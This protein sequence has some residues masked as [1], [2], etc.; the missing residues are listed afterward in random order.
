MHM[1]SA[2]DAPLLT[3]LAISMFDERLPEASRTQEEG[4][5][6]A[7]HMVYCLLNDSGIK[8]NGYRDGPHKSTH[9]LE[10]EFRTTVET[11]E[12]SCLFMKKRH[13]DEIT[14]LVRT[15]DISDARL[16]QNFQK[17]VNTLMVDGIRWGRIVALFYFTSVLAERLYKEGHQSKI[18]SLIGWLSLFSNETVVP[19]VSQQRGGWVSKFIS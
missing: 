13:N 8:F 15:L 6:L 19:W 17:S 18:E 14:Q 16:H 1:A 9:K 4:A 2:V 10:Q 3:N 11:F 12:R 7:R 5:F